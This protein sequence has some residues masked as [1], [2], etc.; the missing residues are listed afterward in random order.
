MF[1][2]EDSKIVSVCQYPE[3]RNQPS[4]ANISPTVVIDISM[5]DLHDYYIMENQKVDF[6]L[7][8]EIEF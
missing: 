7:N 3:I 5:E 6:F 2:Y 1:P 4:F 8:V